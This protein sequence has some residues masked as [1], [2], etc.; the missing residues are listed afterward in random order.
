MRLRIFAAVV[1]LLFVAACG[2]GET[3]DAGITPFI[4]GTE[5]IDID[6]LDT[7]TEVFDAGQDAFDVTIKLKNQGEW[8]VSK[9]NARVRLSGVNPREFGKLEEEFS[10]IPQD[11]VSKKWKDSEGNILDSPPVTVEFKNLNYLSALTGAS[12]EFP[13]LASICYDYCL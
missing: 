8:D 6:F 4:G 3:A 1:I 11:D 10:E 2:N 9:E 12:L 5:G 13:L 7:R